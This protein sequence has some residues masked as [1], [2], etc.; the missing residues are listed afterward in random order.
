[1]ALKL[2]GTH[3]LLGTSK[4][5]ELWPTAW[6]EPIV[7]WFL[8]SSGLLSGVWRTFCGGFRCGSIWGRLPLR[9]SLRRKTVLACPNC[10]FMAEKG[11]LD[12][13]RVY[14]KLNTF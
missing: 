9:W 2:L 7:G 6:N 12:L 3:I 14:P 10:L 1:V 4:N 5:W 13:L 11:A 8:L